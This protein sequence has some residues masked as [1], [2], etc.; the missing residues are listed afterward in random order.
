MVS[1][2]VQITEN[3]LGLPESL[4]VVPTFPV[5]RTISY[6]HTSSLYTGLPSPQ[7]I[8]GI[9]QFKLISYIYLHPLE[10]L[11]QGCLFIIFTKTR[12]NFLAWLGQSVPIL[13][14][15]SL[16]F[17]FQVSLYDWTQV[18]CIVLQRWPI[19]LN[20]VCYFFYSFWDLLMSFLLFIFILTFVL[21]CIDQVR[22]SQPDYIREILFAVFNFFFQV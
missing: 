10:Q 3:R 20:H 16:R 19:L 1:A 17:I 21:V 6:R 18:V 2:V 9:S 7:N 13:K 22:C 12:A 15:R 8:I 11:R 4:S 14:S 5:I